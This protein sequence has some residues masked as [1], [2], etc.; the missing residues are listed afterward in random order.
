[1]AHRHEGR[2]GDLWLFELSRNTNLRFT[3]DDSQD[4]SSPIWSPDGTR[5]AFASTH[6][7]CSIST[8]PPRG[9]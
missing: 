2:G 7:S 8:G 3:F 6:E 1:M 4:N 5:I 9:S